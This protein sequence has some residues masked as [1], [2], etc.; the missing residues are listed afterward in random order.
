[1]PARSV[2]IERLTKFTGEDHRLLTPSQYT[3]LAGRAGRRGIDDRGHVWVLWSPWLGYEQVAGLVRSREFELRSA[4]RPNYNM[5]ANLVNRHDR[6]EALDLL[7]SSFGQ[8]QQSR[9]VTD[10]AAE[11]REARR[12]AHHL[13]RELVDRLGDDVDWRSL[14]DEPG[15][16]RHAVEAALRDL[17]PGDAARF[18]ATPGVVLTVAQRKG[19]TEVGYVESSGRVRRARSTTLDDLPR[20]IG[21]VDLPVPYAPDDAEFRAETAAA[22]RLLVGAE[23]PR[24]GRGSTR[25]SLVRR[26]RKLQRLLDD[27][28]HLERRADDE[29]ASLVRLF[30]EVLHVLEAWGY[31]R[32]WSL[33]EAGH[34]LRR[35]YHESDLLVAEALRRGVFDDLPAPDLAGVVSALVYERRGPGAGEEPWYPTRRLRERVAALTECWERLAALEERHGLAPTR[36]PDGSA[37][38]MV[39]A[40]AAGGALDEVIE[41]EDLSGGDFVRIARLVIDLLGQI[42]RAAP[43][44]ETRAAAARAGEGLRRGIVASSIELPE[45]GGG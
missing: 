35:I 5:A 3:Q 34:V 1:M 25:R 27:A 44:A 28:A 33:T 30:D 26:A 24:E 23:G 10:L 17:R 11:A 16:D 19:I 13:E 42:A 15:A 7:R 20:V 14:L 41:D 32:G 6:A 2:V 36:P 31:V 39:Q 4:F 18:G 12:E 43:T 45:D 9:R 22:L 40:W 29:A 38:A 37:V 8:Y 21:R